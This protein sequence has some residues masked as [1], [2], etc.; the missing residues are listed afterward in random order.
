M[1]GTGVI[2]VLA[3]AA[4]LGATRHKR[5]SDNTVVAAQKSAPALFHGTSIDK[6]AP[7]SL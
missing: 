5:T 4:D 7:V 3:D 2:F 6:M 1:D